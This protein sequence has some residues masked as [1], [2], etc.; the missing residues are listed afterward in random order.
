MR[1]RDRPAGL[2]L[3]EQLRG[4]QLGVRGEKA[5]HFTADIAR[6]SKDSRPNHGQLYSRICINMQVRA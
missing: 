1:F 4:S 2:A 5:K 3:A 6:G